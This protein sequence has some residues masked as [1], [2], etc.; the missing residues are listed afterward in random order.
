MQTEAQYIEKIAALEQVNR[1]LLESKNY[2]KDYSDQL[3]RIIQNFKRNRFGKRSGAYHHPDQTL[4]D[5]INELEPAKEPK[6]ETVKKNRFYN[7][8]SNR[9]S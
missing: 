2:Y 3:H 4:F 8:V 5:F 7:L 1:E 6:Q 9:V